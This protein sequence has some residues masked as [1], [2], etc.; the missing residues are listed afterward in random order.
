M[1]VHLHICI[2]PSWHAAASLRL[3][4]SKRVQEEIWGKKQILTQNVLEWT[5]SLVVS[6]SWNIICTWSG[7]GARHSALCAR[8]AGRHTKL[9]SML[10]HSRKESTSRGLMSCWWSAASMLSGHPAASLLKAA[11]RH[12]H[13]RQYQC[14]TTKNTQTYTVRVSQDRCVQTLTHLETYAITHI[15]NPVGRTVTA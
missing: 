9:S 14:I 3:P 5:C 2:A 8:C 1:Y 10:E 12:T 7:P 4:K 11:W 15:Y 6:V 13:T